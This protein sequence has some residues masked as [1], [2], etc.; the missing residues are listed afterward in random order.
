MGR[1]SLRLS[2]E[3][4]PYDLEHVARDVRTVMAGIGWFNCEKAKDRLWTWTYKVL[5][6]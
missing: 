4:K 3:D 6:D 1:E 2:E 5:G